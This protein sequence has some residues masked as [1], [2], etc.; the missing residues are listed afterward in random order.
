M[1]EYT[2][3]DAINSAMK[4]NVSDFKSAVH[5]LLTQKVQDALEL[6][7]LKV[8]SNF[9]SAEVDEEDFSEEEY[10]VDTEGETDGDQEI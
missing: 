4:D 8:A 5:D 1:S 9:M 2:T 6:K 3:Q 7:R 10:E